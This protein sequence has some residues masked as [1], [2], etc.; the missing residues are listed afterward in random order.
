M[1]SLLSIWRV[2]LLA[3]KSFSKLVVATLCEL[4]LWLLA[5]HV[6]S[7]GVSSVMRVALPDVGI[8][9]NYWLELMIG[10]C[11]AASVFFFVCRWTRRVYLHDV[12][13]QVRASILLD[14]VRPGSRLAGDGSIKAPASVA[15]RLVSEMLPVVETI[16]TLAA[17]VVACLILAIAS[18]LC[19]FVTLAC[20]VASTAGIA[21]VVKLRANDVQLTEHSLTR[22]LTV[23]VNDNL[24]C[25]GEVEQYGAGPQRNARVIA[26]AAAR[27]RAALSATV[28]VGIALAVDLAV[29][30]AM[31]VLLYVRLASD[32][33]AGQTPAF[34]ALLA[35]AGAATLLIVNY[36]PRTIMEL[37]VALQ[38][39]KR[40]DAI[41][42]ADADDV[43]DALDAEAMLSME[44]V[45]GGGVDGGGEGL[46]SDGS[47]ENASE[48]VDRASASA[49]PT[50]FA[51]VL[52]HDVCCSIDDGHGLQGIDLAIAPGEFVSVQCDD[53]AERDVLCALLLRHA[54]PDRGIIALSGTRLAS[55]S[56]DELRSTIV[57]VM[58]ETA[59]FPGSIRQNLRLG[60]PSA[61]DDELEGVLRKVGLDFV[62]ELEDGLG[63]G[64]DEPAASRLSEDGLMRQRLGLARAILSPAKLIVMNDP[65][66]DLGPIQEAELLRSIVALKGSRSVLFVSRT[67]RLERL[68]DASYKLDGG[69]IH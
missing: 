39:V 46:D 18:P 67:D 21:I 5:T 25:A 59:L 23:L 35:A 15:Q 66:G 40:I 3:R 32:V 31:A 11:L 26:D 43:A 50:T 1:S 63:T 57:P 62:L 33:A 8:L 49:D 22:S 48:Q 19:G 56:E 17:S 51:G 10:F 14:A 44:V 20:V 55:V 38:A 13:R 36:R 34:S 41:L 69:R 45:D 52:L 6:L 60:K 7:V 54:E 61:F 12:A 29:L 16:S 42:M 4:G 65:T 27:S 37:P 28:T 9:A 64:V 47:S 53:E 24:R 68:A 2:A 30:L 58:R